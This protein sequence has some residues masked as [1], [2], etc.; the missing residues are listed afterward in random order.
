MEW[1]NYN[2]LYY[3]WVIAKEGSVTAAAKKLRLSQS[4]LS[5]QLKQLEFTTGAQLFERS[6]K[7]LVLNQSGTIA[8]EYCN[9]IFKTGSELFAH[10]KGSSTPSQKVIRVGSQVSLSRNLQFQFL[11]LGLKSKN[12]SFQITQ[13]SLTE[14]SRYLENHSIDL[15][16]TN[17]PLD[18]LRFNMQQ[19]MI[20]P[21]C[22]IGTPEICKKLKK[23]HISSLDDVPLFLPTHTNPTRGELDAFFESKSIHSRVIA[24]VE[25]AALMRLFALSGKGL[26]IIP[27]IVV[28]RELKVKDVDILYE[29]QK[30]NEIFYAITLKRNKPDVVI[31]SCIDSFSI[32]LNLKKVKSR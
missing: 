7:R 17:S 29:F 21:L 3:F 5:E 11:Q 23:N 32:G 13:G 19:L 15:A 4:N 8:F 30:I 10:F 28:S 14:L 26:A 9:K 31:Q 22:A 2:H 18:S 24:E 27:K 12:I 6:K 1:I 20:D 25:D 16:L